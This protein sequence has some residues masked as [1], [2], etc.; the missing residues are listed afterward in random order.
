VI[1]CAVTVDGTDRD[2]KATHN[3][4]KIDDHTLGFNARKRGRE[5]FS[6]DF[7]QLTRA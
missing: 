4:W 5:L 3:E 2:G 7:A 1:G 6:V